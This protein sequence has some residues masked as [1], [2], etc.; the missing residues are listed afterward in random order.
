MVARADKHSI[1]LTCR[2][3]IWGAAPCRDQESHSPDVIYYLGSASP[4]GTGLQDQAQ[5]TLICTHCRDGAGSKSTLLLGHDPTFLF[6]LC[7]DHISQKDVLNVHWL[8]L[9]ETGPGLSASES[10]P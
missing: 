10:G 7:Q 3:H 2:L 6:W 9:A 8:P 1:R 5:D 4:T